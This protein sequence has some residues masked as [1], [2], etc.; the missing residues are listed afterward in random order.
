MIERAYD[1]VTRVLLLLLVGSA[2]AALLCTVPGSG[3][4]STGRRRLSVVD[5]SAA[6]FHVI[7]TKHIVRDVP[8]VEIIGNDQQLLHV[9]LAPGQAC[10]AEP[11]CMIH[12]DNH[13][14]TEVDV[15]TGGCFGCFKRVII[16]G[17]SLVRVH[18]RNTDTVRSRMVA[19]GATFPAQ[20]VPIN[21][22]AWH[23]EVFV[24]RRCFLAA[25]DPDI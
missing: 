14:R 8:Y 6:G 9:M 2:I 19:L 15:G 24:K 18:W 23:G 10:W 11:G 12:C 22:D 16:A 7:D 21:L 4:L 13:V 5:A 17:D 25:F 20:V 3:Q 1:R